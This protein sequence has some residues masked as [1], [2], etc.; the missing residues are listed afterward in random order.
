MF[1]YCDWARVEP[2]CGVQRA[3]TRERDLLRQRSGAAGH[4]D[5]MSQHMSCAPMA[6]MGGTCAMA[7]RTVVAIRAVWIEKGVAT[8]SFPGERRRHLC[9][10]RQRDHANRDRPEQAAHGGMLYR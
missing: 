10:E 7:W 3:I 8:S 9:D 5:E 4:R 2:G 1:R 6:L